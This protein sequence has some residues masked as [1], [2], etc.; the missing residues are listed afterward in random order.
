MLCYHRK[1]VALCLVVHEKC[2]CYEKSTDESYALMLFTDSVTGNSRTEA[3]VSKPLQTNRV[4]K[5]SSPF[6][7]CPSPRFVM[8]YDVLEADCASVFR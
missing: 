6:G 2:M 7:L 4:L 1:K 5:Q 3:L 8:V